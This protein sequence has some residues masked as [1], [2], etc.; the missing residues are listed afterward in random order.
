MSKAVTVKD[1]PAN[2]FIPALATHLKKKFA[3]AKIELPD[4]HDRVKTAV[5]KELSPADDD[6]YFTRAASLA[7]RVYIKGGQGVGSL[8]VVYGGSER[9]GACPNRFRRASGAI[10]RHALQD[11]QTL[12]IVDVK[13]DKSGRW[14]TK[15]GR[16]E[17]DTIASQIANK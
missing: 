3:D 16:H 7:R 9:R 11:L 2:V 10:I 1:I 4:W 14:V 5:F 12:D 6:W 8:R 13:K 17:L 15:N